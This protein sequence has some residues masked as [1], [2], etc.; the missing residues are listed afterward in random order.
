M[1]RTNTVCSLAIYMFLMLVAGKAQAQES[2]L[3]VS[4]SAWKGFAVH[5]LTKIEPDGTTLPG[6]VTTDIDRVQH[7]I[8][9]DAHKRFFGYDL[10][11]EAASDANTAQI[12]IEPLRPT[13][14]EA[15]LASAGWT[16]LALPQYPVIPNVKPGD[17]IA[18]DLLVNAATGQKI[19]DYLTLRRRGAVSYQRKAVDFTLAYV[20]MTLNQPQVAWRGTREAGGSVGVSGAAVW[21]YVPGHGRYILSLLPNEKLGF[22]QWGVVSA[23]GLLFHDLDSGGAEVTV[24]C[25]SRIAPGSGNYHLYVV[26]QPDWRPEGQDSFRIGSADK[27]EWAIAKK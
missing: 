25:N 13:E 19:V 20:E 7:V 22:K 2:N 16:M 18:I 9:D 17:T 27:P 24:E 21:L 12:R 1:S 23:E 6:G 3:S 15:R 8:K 14:R 10:R 26:H 5:F 4:S 11:V